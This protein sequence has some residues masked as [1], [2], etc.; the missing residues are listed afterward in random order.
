MTP[1]TLAELA[2]A[3]RWVA[4]QTEDRGGKPT[5]L[6]Y[7]PVNGGGNAHADKPGTWGTRA[8]AEARAGTL[9]KPCGSGGIG[10]ELG[11]LGDGRIMGGVDL[12]S[13]RSPDGA[14]APWALEVV[15]RL[16][17]Y[18][19]VSPSGTGAKVFF[20]VN[21]ADLPALAAYLT[22]SGAKLFKRRGGVHPPSIE[23]YTGAR[24][25][26]LTE[27]HLPD[28]PAE[29]R[30]VP[31]DVLLWLLTQAG[32]ALSGPAAKSGGARGT[33]TARPGA[34]LSRS[35]RAFRRGMEL[36]RRGFTFEQMAEAL[37][38]DPETAAWVA[39]KG[40]ADGARE[41]RRIWDRAGEDAWKQRWQRNESGQPLP[42]LANAMIA[43]RDDPA[44]RG[45]LAYDQMQRCAFVVS[46]LPGE[47][48]K[49]EHT[50]RPIGDTDVAMIQEHMQLAGLTRLG[51]E[52]AHQAV[53]LCASER[54]FHPV[55]QYLSGLCW[56]RARRAGSWLVDYLGAEDTP[57][58]RAIGMLFLV[59]A[60]AR[61]FEPGCK[62]DYMLIL[63]GPQ[64]L[65]KSTACAILGGPWYS[66]SLPDIRTEG[67]DTAQHLN[68]KWLLEVPEL[69]ALGRAEAASLKAFLSRR[70]EQY[71][72][73]Y[74]RREVVEPR[75]CVMIGTTNKTAYLRDETG[76]R[77][78][79]PVKV[80]AIDTDGLARDRDQ[81]FAEAVHLYQQGQ[82]WWPTPGFE[83]EHIAPQQSERYE[84]DA[85]EARIG[86]YLAPR[87]AALVI[88]VARE[89][90]FI[91]TPKLGTADQRRITAAMERLG[92]AKGARGS[93]GERFWHPR[94]TA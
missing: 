81:L 71:R 93:K 69:S 10:L 87:A 54:A 77:R 5:K 23:F 76:G 50:F 62:A 82:Q 25:F 30:P 4:W 41:L 60:V 80:S 79:W 35:A 92:W 17:S 34:D 91:D 55:R 40:E 16:G 45:A 6:P 89:A 64:G 22:P 44:L 90:L 75:M 14:L 26:A 39:E 24:Y 33:E 15:Q 18:A 27:Q 86:G 32:P 56:D 9:P 72:P 28:T 2:A 48:R 67:K 70:V 88:D 85:W 52:T 74:G 49:P 78:F 19:E 66:D 43:L 58:A 37:P 63:E 51:K 7:S 84:E 53:D 29:L 57:Y 20:L 46:P 36:R 11:A 38:A 13:C 42:N 47:D 59:S 8:Q 83:A 31:R 21:P 94:H 3:P 65:R 12:D 1:V 68:G 73:S 61:V